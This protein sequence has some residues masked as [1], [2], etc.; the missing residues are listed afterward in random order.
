M[1]YYILP[2][3]GLFFPLDEA[4][5]GFDDALNVEFDRIPLAWPDEEYDESPASDIPEWFIGGD[6]LLAL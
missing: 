2:A 6:M 1:Q 5:D 3:F 4:F